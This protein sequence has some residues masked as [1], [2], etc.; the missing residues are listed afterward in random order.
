[1]PSGPDQLAGSVNHES[2]EGIMRVLPA[3]RATA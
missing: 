2:S 3:P 1:M